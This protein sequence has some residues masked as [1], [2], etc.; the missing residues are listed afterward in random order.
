MIFLTYCWF[1]GLSLIPTPLDQVPSGSAP[2]WEQLTPPMRNS[3]SPVTLVTQCHGRNF[4]S[5]VSFLFFLAR[6]SF[7]FT[8]NGRS[9]FIFFSDSNPPHREKPVTIDHIGR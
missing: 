4:S 2:H 5:L 6:I 3:L 7:L 9:S 1:R 8:T